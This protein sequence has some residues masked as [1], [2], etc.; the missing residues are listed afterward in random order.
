[1]LQ[2]TQSEVVAL[3]AQGDAR[4]AKLHEAVIVGTE[5]TF[6]AALQNLSAVKDI[7]LSG[8]YK[9]LE[10]LAKAISELQTIE[11]KLLALKSPMVELNNMAKET[12][13]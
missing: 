3:L 10:S 5:L 13:V 1:M 7:T 9:T 12:S 6:T 4:R 11:A 8:N 2:A